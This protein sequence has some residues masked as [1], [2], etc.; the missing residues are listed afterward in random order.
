M[1]AFFCSPLQEELLH[2]LLFPLLWDVT[3]QSNTVFSFQENN[4]IQDCSNESSFK[5]FLTLYWHNLDRKSL[6][7]LVNEN[8]LHSLQSL[9]ET[10][11]VVY[12]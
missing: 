3:G 9:D 6:N 7:V 1:N 10:S 5:L 8:F 11:V 4:L 2:L 12:G